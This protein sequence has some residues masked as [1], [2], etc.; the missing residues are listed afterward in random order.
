[1]M[2][3]AQVFWYQASSRISTEKD[4]VFWLPTFNETFLPN[5]ILN[6]NDACM[7]EFQVN[8]ALIIVVIGFI[9]AQTHWTSSVVV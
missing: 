1:M 4:T 6:F 5:I 7:L 3:E 2:L 8:L 9:L